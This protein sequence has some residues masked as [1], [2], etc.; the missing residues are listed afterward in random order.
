MS[1]KDRIL[2][3]F[4]RVFIGIG[5]L[6]VLVAVGGCANEFLNDR[7]AKQFA[8]KARTDLRTGGSWE[9]F[10]AR[11]PGFTM[12]SLAQARD[13]AGV[14]RHRGEGDYLVQG[15]E[16]SRDPKF[17]APAQAVQLLTRVAREKENCRA[18]TMFY[19]FGRFARTSL[20]FEVNEALAVSGEVEVK[21]YR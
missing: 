12:V 10:M 15:A 13:C 5:V 21:A 14:S 7:R 2:L 16:A 9:E 17:V 1:L 4:K 8:D 19:F 11:N 3:G 6:L 18:V 20:S